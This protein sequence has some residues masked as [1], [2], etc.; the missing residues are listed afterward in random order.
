M[1]VLFLYTELAEY[2]LACIEALEQHDVDITIVR[3]PV[4]SE[5]PFKFRTLHKAKIID[6]SDFS[7]DRLM[8]MAQTLAP[9]LIIT[10]GWIDKSYLKVCRAMRSTSTT[11]LALD[12]QW[13]GRLKQQIAR[14]SAPFWVKRHFAKAWVP[15][16]PQVQ[17]AR[18][19]GFGQSDIE[20][21]FYCADTPLFE[22]LFTERD[23]SQPLPKRFIFVGRYLAFKGI[24]DLW[25]AFAAVREDHP[26]WELIC[27]GTGALWDERPEQPGLEH[28]GF[29]QPSDLPA[30]LQQAGV[31]ILP[32]HYE[33]WGVVVHEM[34]AAG[35][36]M[37]CADSVGAATSFL[38][39]GENGFQFQAGSAK[40][41]E[42]AMRRMAEA[43]DKERTQM[44]K[45]SHRIAMELTP[46]K[47]VQKLLLLAPVKHHSTE[48]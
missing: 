8:E 11:V 30:E 4:N 31:F 22:Q 5:A 3:W 37:I 26:D 36:P 9:D 23:F 39:E 1:K 28:R 47:W 41:L 19:L 44:A 20:T 35:F 42:A 21:G 45:A 17:Y 15:G 32:S 10:S 12:N 38:R 2:F 25:N 14:L 48:S 6:R 18:K 46:E 34:A 40:A 33:P 27:V 16:V 7:D 43:S 24:F 13:E 29:I